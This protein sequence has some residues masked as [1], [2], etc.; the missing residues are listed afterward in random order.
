MPDENN[1]IDPNLLKTLGHEI[2]EVDEHSPGADQKLKELAER[3]GSFHLCKGATE[4]GMEEVIAIC[5]EADRIGA[6][7]DSEMLDAL[8]G[9]LSPE[10]L[11]QLRS[12][13]P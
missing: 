5:N 1:P 7:P 8:E 12:E 4:E 6:L 10:L 2:T 9:D 3:L 13:L 11:D